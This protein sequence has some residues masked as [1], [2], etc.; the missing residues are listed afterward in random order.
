MAANPIGNDDQSVF[1]IYFVTARIH[2][3]ELNTIVEF[4]N[5]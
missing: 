4:V 5:V 1:Y 2:Y 3:S